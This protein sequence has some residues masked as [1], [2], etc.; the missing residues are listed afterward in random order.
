MRKRSRY[1]PKPVA[2]NVVDFVLEN[3]SPVAKHGGYLTTLK[4]KN[5]L[6]MQALL[7]GNATRDDMD[8]IV[9]MSNIAEALVDL[10]FGADYRAVSDAGRNAIVAIVTRSV[11]LKR[12]TPA[13]PEIRALNELMELH[14][15][16]MDAITVKDMDRAIA[17]A[18]KQMRR[19]RVEILPAVDLEGA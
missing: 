4:I 2:L 11:A 16:Q 5:S 15:A 9:A 6:A 3:M 1:R 8:A 12:Y 19:G 14:D 18:K 13:G 7:Q 10:G 17:H